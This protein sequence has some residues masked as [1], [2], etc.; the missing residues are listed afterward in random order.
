MAI[1]IQETYR[2]P[3]R[4]EQKRKSPRYIIIKTLKI[5]KKERLLKA[6]REKDQVTSKG[7]P[8]R[9]TPDFSVETLKARRTDVLQTLR[10]LRGQP[11]LLYLATLSITIGGENKTFHTITK[12]K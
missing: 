9:I 10:D 8:I 12:F 6:P 7:R 4:L 2:T 11:R 5:M 1:K 3:N